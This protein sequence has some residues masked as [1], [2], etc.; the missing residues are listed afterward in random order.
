MGFEN[1]F[2]GGVIREG[3]GLGGENEGVG[4]LISFGFGL[5]VL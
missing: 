3:M 5:S 1:N 4:V 2:R